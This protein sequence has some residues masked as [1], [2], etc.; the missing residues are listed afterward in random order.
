M[1][2]IG[3]LL[4]DCARHMRRMFDER[5][6]GIGVTGPQARL[7]MML[8]AHEGEQQAYYANLLEVEPI[9]LCRMVDR[10]VEAGL[11]ERHA[12]PKDRR[13][14]LLSRSPRALAMAPALQA[15]IKALVEDVESGFT[16][17]ELK[18]LR[19]LLLRLSE[20][21][22]VT[23]DKSTENRNTPTHG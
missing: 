5:M 16:P 8:G 23:Q 7:L 20:K 18:T 6:R 13:A 19:S 14:R 3:Y 9:T 2:D 21:L 1:S 11:I 12:D 22:V 4:A 15:E 17:D 10:M